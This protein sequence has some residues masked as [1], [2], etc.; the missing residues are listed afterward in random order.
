MH[1]KIF[2]QVV[3]T[4]GDFGRNSDLSYSISDDRTVPFTIDA[5]DG[6]LF[7]NGEIR[8]KY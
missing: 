1:C 2:L 4:D 7:A 8:I 5:L 3:A 6:T